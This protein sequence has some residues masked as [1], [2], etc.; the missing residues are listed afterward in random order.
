MPYDW[1]V[2]KGGHSWGIFLWSTAKHLNSFFVSYM[3]QWQLGEVG[4]LFCHRLCLGKPNAIKASGENKQ[5]V[6]DTHSPHHW[7]SNLKWKGNTT[8]MKD[9]I[10]RFIS[11]TFKPLWS[12]PPPHG[13]LFS[14]LER[15]DWRF[16]N[17]RIQHNNYIAQLNQLFWANLEQCVAG[18][19]PATHIRWCLLIS[20]PPNVTGIKRHAANTVTAVVTPSPDCSENH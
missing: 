6:R 17:N 15:F 9:A 19:H 3:Q 8:L 13:S 10:H 2:W 18:I 4:C 1:A 14:S 5:K 20:S 16:C 11:S 12:N 7:I